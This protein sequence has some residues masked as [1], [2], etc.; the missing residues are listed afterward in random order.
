MTPA[1]QAG[2]RRA[3]LV[4]PASNPRMIAKALSLDVDEV[5]LDLEDSVAV[6]QKSTACQRVAEVL[7]GALPSRPALSVRLNGL[8]TP[9]F[10]ADLAMLGSVGSSLATVVLP[11]TE[12]PEDVVKVLGGLDFSTMR[13]QVLIESPR[14][15]QAAA[16]IC[17]TP[18]VEAVIIGYADLAAALGRSG[19]LSSNQWIAVQERVLIDARSANVS[20]IDG[21]HLEVADDAVFRAATRWAKE[22]GFDGKWVIHPS[23]VQSVMSEFTPGAADVADARRV[24]TALEAARLAGN[25]AVQLDGR[26]LDEALAASARRTLALARGGPG[27]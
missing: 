5:V 24:L 8:G 6:E 20:A 4:A 1:P 2:P 18:G 13:V 21:P 17:R 11:K 9:W 26:M 12:S 22:M 7:A 23:Q 16:E 10:D 25:G 14:G 15:V 27:V 19:G 3:V